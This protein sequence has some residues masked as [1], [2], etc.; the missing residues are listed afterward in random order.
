MKKAMTLLSF[1]ILL[2]IPATSFAD[3]EFFV[4]VSGKQAVRTVLVSPKGSPAESGAALLN[5]MAG[6]T[7]ASETNPYLLLIEPGIYDVGTG[8]VQMKEYVDMEGA[9]Q[10]VTTI[11][12]NV[13]SLSSGVLRGANHAEVRNL[14][15]KNTG[16]AFAVA[17]YNQSSSPAM[18]RI[19][20]TASGGSG[21][22]GVYNYNS[23]SPTMTQV[24][25]TAS[26]GAISVGISNDSSSP[27][28][29]QVKA[30]GSGA[31]TNYG[32]YNYN[33]SSPTMT[34]VTVAASGG[35]GTSNYGVANEMSTA[36]IDHSTISG[37]TNSVYTFAASTCF[38]GST[39][40]E[41]GTV[42]TSPGATTTCAGVYDENYTFYPNSCP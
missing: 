18:T 26:G 9:G 17:I 33:S 27:T 36:H 14:A 21:S 23:S 39:R 1:L 20:A 19:T 29:T 22:Y 41:E 24:T 10:N 8:S 7:G 34:Q 38:I 32:V 6:I 15:V 3:G 25:A 5:A 2:M 31:L 28:M 40:L 37:T 16:G 13:D 42:L 30:T 12:G 11:S 4:I 35:G